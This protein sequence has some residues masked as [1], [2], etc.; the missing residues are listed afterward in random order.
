VFYKEIENKKTNENKQS[1]ISFGEEP[2]LPAG[3]AG[4]RL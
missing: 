1:T 2:G 3:Q 4:M